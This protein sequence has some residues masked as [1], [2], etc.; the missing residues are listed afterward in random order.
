[1]TIVV[2]SKHAME[3][4]TISLI[5]FNSFLALGIITLDYYKTFIKNGLFSITI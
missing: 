1:M 4:N 3:N 5:K 2:D